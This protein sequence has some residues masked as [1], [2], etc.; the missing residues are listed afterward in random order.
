MTVTRIG[1]DVHGVFGRAIA[2]PSI[3]AMIRSSSVQRTV[4]NSAGLAGQLLGPPLKHLFPQRERGIVAAGLAGQ[5]LGPPLKPAWPRAHTSR[6][7]MGFEFGRAIARPS[8]EA[9]SAG[10]LSRSVVG[11]RFGRAIA[12]PSI[13]ATLT[14]LWPDVS[15]FWQV[16]PG[17]CSA[18][19]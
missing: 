14:G 12:R 17:N 3:E 2:R 19:H 10:D 4:A 15:R 8:I 9:R 18:L 1:L 7:D 6:L 11:A 16:W 13:E 5:L